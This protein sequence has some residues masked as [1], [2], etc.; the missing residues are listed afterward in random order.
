MGSFE[1]ATTYEL[2]VAV[3]CD[4]A[5]SDRL[6]IIGLSADGVLV[7]TVSVTADALNP[8]FQDLVLTLDTSIHS[9][10]VGKVLRVELRFAHSGPYGRTVYFDDV[11]LTAVSSN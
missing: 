8:G 5:A 3:A 9:A 11:R 4:A 7:D 2:R 6:L 10:A 1:A